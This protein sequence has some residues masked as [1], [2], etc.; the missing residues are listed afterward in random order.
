[1]AI[2]ALGPEHPAEQQTVHALKALLAESLT[3]NLVESR[4]MK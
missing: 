2:S 1:L 4:L 3:G